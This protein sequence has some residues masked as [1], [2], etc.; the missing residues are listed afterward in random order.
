MPIAPYMQ[1]TSFIPSRKL[2]AQVLS[3]LHFPSSFR[4]TL[5]QDAEDVEAGR[6]SLR[7]LLHLSLSQGIPQDLLTEICSRKKVEGNHLD[8]RRALA[9]TSLYKV[10]QNTWGTDFSERE[11]P[12]QLREACRQSRGSL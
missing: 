5:V 8:L 12:V 10:L 2:F 11:I 6:A 7:Q 3:H 1:T 4:Q 9:F